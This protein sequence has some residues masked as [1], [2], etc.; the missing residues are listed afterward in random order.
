MRNRGP[1][2]PIDQKPNMRGDPDYDSLSPNAQAKR[3]EDQYYEYQGKVLQESSRKPK[4]FKT[5]VWTSS[6]HAKYQGDDFGR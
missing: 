4:K 2:R 3:D 1:L 5:Q 6:K